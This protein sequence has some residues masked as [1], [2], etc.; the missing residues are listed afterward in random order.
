MAGAQPLLTALVFAAFV[1]SGSSTAVAEAD[2]P[3][4]EVQLRLT[5]RGGL[6]D[7]ALRVVKTT[8]GALLASAGI[9]ASWR[10]CAAAPCPPDA[11]AT[12]VLVLLM[13]VRKLTDATV[14]GEM[15]RD[16]RSGLVTAV[17]YLP[18]VVEVTDAIR[19][20]AESRSNPALATLDVGHLVGL[21]VAHEVGHGLGLSH[22]ASGVMK[23]RPSVREVLARAPRRWA[24]EAAKW[25][26][27]G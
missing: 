8:T 5:V 25:R 14:S 7:G 15:L 27:C 4:L 1:T 18:R 20:L 17:I 23:A 10:D 2:P 11:G 9:A 21:T 19:N 16:G 3:G 13:P 12:V 24:S 22:A 26:A 6:D